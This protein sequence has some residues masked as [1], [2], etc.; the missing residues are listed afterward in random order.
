MKKC[1]DELWGSIGKGVIRFTDPAK[2][3]LDVVKNC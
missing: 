3:D 1:K 2:I